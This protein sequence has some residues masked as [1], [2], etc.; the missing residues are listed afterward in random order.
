M[1]WKSLDALGWVGLI[2][3]A[4]SCCGFGAFLGG[5]L[6]TWFRDREVP[7]L[8][9]RIAKL[10]ILNADLKASNLALVAAKLALE[11]EVADLKADKAEPEF[12]VAPI[13]GSPTSGLVTGW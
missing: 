4:A 11:K 3:F 7:T 10:E 5:K 1:D 8:K 12:P 13:F 9:A 2:G 6:I